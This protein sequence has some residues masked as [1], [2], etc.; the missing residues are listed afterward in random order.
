ME[1]RTLV[2]GKERLQK[3]SAFRKRERCLDGRNNRLLNDVRVQVLWFELW[4]S[5]VRFWRG[6]Q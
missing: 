2:L 4:A 5:S 6:Q 3:K 1:R